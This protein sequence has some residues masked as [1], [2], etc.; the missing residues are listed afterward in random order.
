MPITT[1]L[2][3]NQI[4]DAKRAAKAMEN[5]ATGWGDAADVTR[6]ESFLVNAAA[7]PALFHAFADEFRGGDKVWHPAEVAALLHKNQPG[8]SPTAT[9]LAAMKAPADVE[10]RKVGNEL[11]NLASGWYSSNELAL[12]FKQLPAVLADPFAFEA[13]KNAMG[14]KSLH[15]DNGPAAVA[16]A[17]IAICKDGEGDAATLKLKR[18]LAAALTPA[19]SIPAPAR[20]EKPEPDD[21][22]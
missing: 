18:L 19:L 7:S 4:D 13:M 10:P 12:M 16:A 22:L 5:I 15:V 17:V 20:A 11:K 2:P 8:A 21:L 6:V 3:R 9:R 1:T 14:G